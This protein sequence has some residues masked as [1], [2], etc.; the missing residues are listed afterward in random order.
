M[1]NIR[2]GCAVVAIDKSR[3]VLGRRGKEPFF[4]KWIIPGG[5]VKLFERLSDTAVREFKEETG[6]SIEVSRVAHIAEI[7]TAPK[8]H[9]IVVYV[10]AYVTGG[11]AQAGSDLLEVG[12]FDRQAVERLAAADELTPTVKD[13]LHKL[14]W[15]GTRIEP[16][17]RDL[18]G[19]CARHLTSRGTSRRK[20]PSPLARHRTGV[21]ARTG[22]VGSRRKADYQQL[23]FADI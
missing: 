22:R 15:L 11:V 6:L 23:I 7:I 18:F 2:V 21:A 12:Y 4:G 1:E 13:V 19:Y 17:G 5:G 8:E 16:D 14:G 10:A 9:R 3:I 20:T